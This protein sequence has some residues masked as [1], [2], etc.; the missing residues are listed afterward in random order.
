M[1]FNMFLFVERCVGNNINIT[2]SLGE[3]FKQTMLIKLG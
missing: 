3:C 2:F 1:C